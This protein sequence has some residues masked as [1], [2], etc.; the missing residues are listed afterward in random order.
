MLGYRLSVLGTLM[1][2][3]LAWPPGS[4]KISYTHNATREATSTGAP[5]F[6][7][8]EGAT[9]AGRAAFRG[10][11][12]KAVSIR[13]EGDRNCASQHQDPVRIQQVEVN[14]Q[15]GL[16]NVFVWVKQ[17]LEGETFQP[18]LAPVILDQKGCM[19]LPRVLGMQTGQKLKVLNS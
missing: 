8:A 1:A 15:A 18:P 6:R 2:G 11:A 16:R 10:T 14:E 3:L 4:T 13:M 12:P 19:Y 17:G 7:T 9:V 5:T